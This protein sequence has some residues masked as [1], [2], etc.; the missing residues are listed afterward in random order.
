MTNNTN[1]EIPSNPLRAVRRN[2]GLTLWR[3]AVLARTNPSLLCAIEK[4]GYNPTASVRNRIAAALD[5]TP[6]E[7]WPD[8]TDVGNAGPSKGSGNCPEGAGGGV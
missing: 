8:P 2:R 6:C 5:V 1:A 7:I 3:L 4:H